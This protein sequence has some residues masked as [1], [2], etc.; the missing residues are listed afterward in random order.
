[1]LNPLILLV[2]DDA[3]DLQFLKDG[4]D[5]CSFTAV[6]FFEDGFS[7]LN[8]L[9]SLDD[10]LKYPALVISD[11]EMPKM[12]G[13]TL[14]TK[15]REQQRYRLID[16]VVLST[17][18]NEAYKKESLHLGAKNYFVK[19]NTFSELAVLTKGFIKMVM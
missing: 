17:F 2:D 9:E 5:S 1:M 18:N 8:Y 13:K 3:D 4:F 16:V 6:A 19:P 11:F 14:I 15:I 10:A 12:D 7:L